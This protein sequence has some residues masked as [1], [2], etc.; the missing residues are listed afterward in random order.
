MAV[1]EGFSGTVAVAGGLIAC[2]RFRVREE[3]DKEE[4]TGLADGRW[5]S[6]AGTL[7]GWTLE[8]EG[9]LD[10]GDTQFRGAAPNLR[11]G[12]TA[13]IVGALSNSTK[14]FSGIV[15]LDSVEI[16]GTREGVFGYT[17]SGTGNGALT[18]PA[19]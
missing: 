2:K 3:A 10:S 12:V 5:K 18:Y 19:S 14:Q 17:I 8:A 15:W 13:S 4:I 1:Y 7:L 16:E 9:V 6:Y 11:A